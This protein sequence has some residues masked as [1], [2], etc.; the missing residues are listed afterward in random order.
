VTTADPTVLDASAAIALLRAEPAARAVARLVALRVDAGPVVVPDH[1]WLEVENV[2]VR[3][4]GWDVDAVVEAFRW[5]DE[6]GIE[7]APVDR[8]LALLTLDHM[9]AAGLTSYDAAYLALA[10]TEKATLVT[11]DE[12]L[13]TAAGDRAVVPGRHATGE[14][15]SI[16]ETAPAARWV[17]HGRYLADLR[18]RHTTA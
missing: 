3:R 16:Y 1:F 14:R 9:T 4:Y 7:T 2:L 11:L 10:D 6:L 8:P 18:A 5:L 13:A 15:R 17:A 12:D